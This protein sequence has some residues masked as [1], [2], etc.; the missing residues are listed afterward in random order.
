MM[1]EREVFAAALQLPVAERDDY[2]RSRCSN[3]EQRARIHALLR[4]HAAAPDDLFKFEVKTREI[5]SGGHEQLDEFKILHRLGEGGMGEVYLAQDT[6]L[7]RRVALKV[8]ARHLI[9]SE[10]ALARFRDEARNAAVLNHPAIVPVY[11]FGQAGDDWYLV[12]EFVDG[13]TLTSVIAEQRERV[14]T[15][16]PQAV[17]DWHRRAAEIVLAVAEALEC[18]HRANIVHRDVKPSNI[19]MDP[20]RGARLAD[21]GIAKHL[22]DDDR[23]QTGIIGTCHYMSPEQADLSTKRVD[24]R[25]DIFSL[26]V[27]LYE[28]LALRRPFDGTSPSQVLR[29]IVESTPVR[30]RSIDRRIPVDL[31]TICQKTIE[32]QPQDRYPTAAHV[33]ADLRCFL[34]GE[35]IL[36][37]P[38]SRSRVAARW[39]RRRWRIVA[40]VFITA[41]LVGVA[42]GVWHV[43]Q[44]DQRERCHAVID[45]RESGLTLRVARLNGAILEPLP[46]IQD[47]R[48]PGE[49]L[50]PSG[51]Y[52][53][54]AT[55]PTGQ[56]SEA[57]V[58]LTQPGTIRRITVP[59]TRNQSEFTNMVRF[60]G[61][62][63]RFRDSTNNDG[64]NL[65][66]IHLGPFF[67]DAT[68]VSNSEY[69]AF[70]VATRHP[71][72][73]H[74]SRFGY[75]TG[76]DDRPVVGI[77][78]EDAN[79]YCQF[80]GKRL[81]T[82]AEWE[83][84]M[85]WPDG[86][87]NPWKDGAAVS[88]PVSTTESIGRMSAANLT[89]NRQEYEAH[90]L[91]VR[92]H[93]EWSSAAGLF[94]GSTNV[95]EF[96]ESIFGGA[97]LQV[98]VKGASWA[99]QPQFHDLSEIQTYPLETEDE[100]GERRGAWSMKIGFRCARSA[101][102]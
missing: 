96:T 50:V 91:G 92:A 76:L 21:F 61:G 73:V 63:F 70:L 5:A 27:V 42:A 2:V 75:P 88:L 20:R 35:P 71:E 58:V 84:A 79:A 38:T 62:D 43:R 94:H 57:T 31:E 4:H 74:W 18:A 83:F 24:Q 19:L 80:V 36:A 49:F 77:T 101:L 23:T 78:W 8:L 26:G 39:L 3:E 54:T 98:I 28:L 46:D 66:Q 82:A 37:R 65:T 1:S 12:T 60:E 59:I 95:S 30:L 48:V 87:R 52:R 81:P 22:A 10:R 15:R 16:S 86:R 68:E 29:A 32:K 14:G 7:G 69:R 89:I 44:R 97:T 64:T 9:G 100:H 90:T 102:P 33:A 6:V 85:R 72:P 34:N 45:S 55:A 11:K 41:V 17:R 56:F 13:P 40:S 51:E 93:P 47:F 25:T 53:I 99:Q 67:M